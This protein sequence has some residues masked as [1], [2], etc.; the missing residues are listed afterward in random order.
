MLAWATPVSFILKSAI[1]IAI[2][3]VSSLKMQTGPRL[4]L[5]IW[6]DGTWKRRMSAITGSFDVG[7][8]EVP[9]SW[10]P[11]RTGGRT[12]IPLTGS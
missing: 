10:L 5:L 4:I 6:W 8:R 1:A 11:P 7:F 3:G 9:F 2:F 12:T